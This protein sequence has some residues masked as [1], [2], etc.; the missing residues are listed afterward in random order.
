MKQNNV[1][2]WP[3]ELSLFFLLVHVPLQLGQSCQPLVSPDSP[4]VQ[5]LHRDV[6]DHA[7]LKSGHLCLVCLSFLPTK[8]EDE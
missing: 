2:K 6:L 8:N 1:R 5:F 7:G 4:L 3:A